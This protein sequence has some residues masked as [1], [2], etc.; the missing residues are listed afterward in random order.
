MISYLPGGRMG[1]ALFQSAMMIATA[2]RNGT[3]YSMPRQTSS[4]VWSPI[5]FPYLHNPKW[6]EGRVDMIIDEKQFHYVPLE[7]DKSWNDLQVVLRG[8]W[9]DQ[10]YFKDYKDEVIAAFNLPWNHKPDICSIHARYGDYLTIPGK[11]IIIDDDYLKNAIDLI[12]DKTGIKRFKVFSDDI[13][14]FK[15]RHGSLYPFEYS[16]N[17]NEVDDLIEISCCASHINSSSTFS[18]WGAYLNKNP[19]KIIVTQ[20]DWFRMGWDGADTSGIIPSE[21]IK[22]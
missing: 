16:T 22:I 14:L 2:L 18:W 20:R 11:H 7:Y 9:Q 13:N 21:W 5:Y 12:Q 6:Q 19:D 15:N 4:S 8:Y 17:D 1:N 3:E 10:R